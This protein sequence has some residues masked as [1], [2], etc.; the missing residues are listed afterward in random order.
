MP[1]LTVT[2][3]DRNLGDQTHRRTEATQDGEELE[4]A[5]PVLN[6]SSYAELNRLL[7]PT[8]QELLETITQHDPG[9]ISTTARLVN[10]DYKQV[11]RNLT[12]LA[13]I[14]MIE[15][16]EAGLGQPKQPLIAYDGLE[17]HVTF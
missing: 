11:H 7:C 10:R 8:N 2:V 13:D 17:A 3:D 4:D 14:G 5:H 12:E 1:T 9:S 15:F 16:D 6:F